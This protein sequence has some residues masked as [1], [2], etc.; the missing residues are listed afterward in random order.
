MYETSMKAMLRVVIVRTIKVLAAAAAAAP[1]NPT[2]M[3]FA[4]VNP[5][6]RECPL[7]THG[8]IMNAPRKARNGNHNRSSNQPGLLVPE[9]NSN[10]H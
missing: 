2:I 9:K 4:A 1:L 3:M 6:S 10:P 5:D 8:P 7:K